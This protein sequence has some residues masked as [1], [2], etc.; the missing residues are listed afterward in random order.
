ML[1]IENKVVIT[2][3]I[4]FA[5]KLMANLYKI[6]LSIGCIEIVA[7][8][9]IGII[10]LIVILARNKSRVDQCPILSQRLQEDSD[11]SQ[12]IIADM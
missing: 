10:F 4:V 7:A 1:W 8:H 2:D 3:N 6:L 5:M 12:Q 11:Q 9:A